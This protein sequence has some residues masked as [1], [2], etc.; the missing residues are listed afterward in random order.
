[1]DIRLSEMP[2]RFFRLLGR[3]PHPQ[4]DEFVGEKLTA[5]LRGKDG[6]SVKK[7]LKEFFVSN[8]DEDVQ[9][10]IEPFTMDFCLAMSVALHRD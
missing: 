10:M 1:M 3:K 6:P 7:A 2:D 8:I 9:D 5:K 4:Q